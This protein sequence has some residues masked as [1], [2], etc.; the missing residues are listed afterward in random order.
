MSKIIMIVLMFALIVLI[1][2]LGHFLAARFFKVRVNEFAIGMGPKL[3]GVKRGD[4]L[5]SIRALPLGGFCAIEGEGGESYAEDSMLS[6]KPWQKFIIFAAGAIM[7]MLLA[8][9]IFSSIIG[10]T[11]YV[12]NV[13]SVVEP[14]S[15]ASE[16]GLQVGDEILSI[17]GIQTKDFKAILSVTSSSIK[18]HSFEVKD[19]NNTI[20]TLVI[21]PKQNETG[22][23]KYGFA[24]SRA[25]ATIARSVIGGLENSIDAFIEILKAF[26]Q[27]ITG[28]VPMNE[29]AGIVGVVQVSSQM[30]DQGREYSLMMAIMNVLNLAGFLSANLAVF[31]LLPIPA[32]DGGRILFALIEMIRRKPIDPEKEGMIHFAGFVLLM[33]LMVFVLYNDIVR[34]F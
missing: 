3:F 10:Y 7:N 9:V 28:K 24:G 15:A 18:A 16:A 17:D 26:G 20:K 34:I 27:L 13:V 22:Q 32:L 30:W 21:T 33:I 4:T 1:H 8:W 2:E 31:N 14:N 12:N 23:Y 5:Y 11:G 25:K 6:K 19:A 29:L